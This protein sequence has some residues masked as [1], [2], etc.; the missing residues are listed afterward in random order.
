[1]LLLHALAFLA[2][3][4]SIQFWPGLPPAGAITAGLGGVLLGVLVAAVRGG[5]AATLFAVAVFG[6]VLAAHA[7]DQR[8]APPLP[9]AVADAAVDLR[10]VVVGL[11]DT[12]DDRVRFRYRVESAVLD[13]RP[14]RVP[15]SLQ[16]TAYGAP[17]FQ[18]QPGDRWHLRARIRS[19]TGHANPGGFDY[20]RWLFQQRVDAVGNI[21]EATRAQ[22]LSSASWNIDRFRVY[23]RTAI[24]QRDDRH[25]PEILNA[26]AV[27]DRGPITQDAWDVLLATGT[28]H[29]MA[30]S[31]LHVG[32]A[33]AFGFLL[34]RGGWRLLPLP[35]QG[36]LPRPIA[37]ALVGLGLAAVYAALAGFAIPTQRALLML[38]VALG[39]LTLRRR[40]A[41][42]DALAVALVGVLVVDPLAP[43]AP[44]FWLSFGA[45]GAILWV[46]NGRLGK[47]GWLAD[48][49]RLQLAISLA[50]VPLLLLLFGRISVAAPLANI[51]AVPW[52]SLLVVPP[53]LA[54][55]LVMPLLPAAGEWLLHVADT[56]FAVLWPL[57]VWLADQPWSEW[58]RP[59]PALPMMLVAVV[60]IL[61]LLAPRGVPGKV[62][63]CI[64]L[65]PLLLAPVAR[66]PAGTLWLDVLDAGEGV[67]V[68]A[69]TATSTVVVDTG[70]AG[71]GGF[72]GGS[73]VVLP[74]LRASGVR[75]LDHLVVTREHAN[76]AGGVDAIRAAMPI[77][78]IWH[79]DG[80]RAQSAD[81]E[82]VPT[83]S[84]R[85]GMGWQDDGVRFTFIH[86]RTGDE[87][88]LA[89]AN[90][91]CLL[92]IDAGGGS[93]LLAA[94]LGERA[95]W[96]LLTRD[97]DLA[98]DVL[99][100]NASGP[101]V[102]EF[103]A[104][105]MP[106]WIIHT[107]GD[108]SRARDWAPPAGAARGQASTQCGG[109]MHVA[110]NAQPTGSEMDASAAGVGSPQ[111]WREERPR[112]WD[113]GCRND[114]KS[115]TIRNGGASAP[116]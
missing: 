70:R 21:V 87:E 40:P 54:G 64:C 51:V 95:E 17:S 110:I 104:R 22:R 85:E 86:P 32:L 62:A 35:V 103:H 74:F 19:P 18:P 36:R 33:A 99:V 23:L 116:D 91:A 28:N 92:R 13:G 59:P 111:A 24:L 96:F 30:I 45:V 60:G 5:R 66:P 34:G 12:D 8:V 115:V 79:A 63:G 38:A 2:G 26:L 65:L 27:G 81:T 88:R 105:I 98:A 93:A 57:L 69:R 113:R 7:A 3:T 102:E 52:V 73:R 112:F 114:G 14:V 10:G 108:M 71:R 48:G 80:G 29:L 75:R 78:R 11:P 68:V 42:G 61:L 44:G 4:A 37:A 56:A 6:L 82:R 106:D 16:L 50:L 109:A 47:L 72:D 20:P 55:T 77:A 76:H 46:V 67:A 39:V 9:P 94:G 1:M 49:I 31:G 90:R 84:C 41:A 58:Q 107:G 53:T 15:E 43:M 101:T 25:H 89:G 100:V 83:R 97:V